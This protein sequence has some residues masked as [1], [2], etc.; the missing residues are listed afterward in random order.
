[1]NIHL[2]LIILI[3]FLLIFINDVSSDH[4]LCW[5]LIP[6]PNNLSRKI[7]RPCPMVKNRKRAAST[8]APA[9]NSDMFTVSFTCSVENENPELC[10]KVKNAFYTAG[11]IIS[12][13]IKLNTPLIVNASLVNFCTTRG[14]CLDGPTGRLTLGG[15]GPSRLIPIEKDQRVYPQS[16]LKQLNKENH[17]EYSPYDINALFNSEGNYWFE[18]DGPIKLNQS[19]FLFVI[20]HELIHGLG[21]CS[22]W[23]D[24]SDMLGIQN[25]I[26]PTPL[27]LTTITGQVIFGGF[28]EFIFDKFMV[29]LSDGTR[30]S[31]LTEELNKFSGVG[32]THNSMD[33][34]LNYFMNTFPSSPEYQIVQK[35]MNISTTPKS[36]GILPL[37]KTDI[38]DAFI[39]ETSLS[40]FLPKS[41]ISHCDYITYTKSSDF[42]MRYL[43]D[44]GI[45]LK[46]S[47]RLGGNYV[48][49]PIG[50]KLAETLSLI[51]YQIQNLPNTFKPNPNEIVVDDE[52]NIAS[53][54]KAFN[55]N[56]LII[57]FLFFYYIMMDF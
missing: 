14:I 38:K 57:K 20:L 2:L 15:A 16:I 54:L 37:N 19:D 5:D 3:T 34:F 31:N 25:I 55:L 30:I 43:Q 33:D 50:P 46:R 28:R 29:L 22:G 40:P 1:M 56:Y 52:I 32:T 7:Q 47:I 8:A 9:N 23:D 26:T 41:S 27:F 42:L 12:S 39:L 17:P 53:S 4:A 6:E 45:S 11:Q 24:H 36:L 35:M 21:F 44:P 13:S 48:N 18:E 49:G 10:R 51:G